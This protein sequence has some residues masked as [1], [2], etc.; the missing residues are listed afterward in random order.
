[1]RLSEDDALLAQQV[2]RQNQQ[3][4][5]LLERL[6]AAELELLAKASVENFSTLKGRVQMLTDILQQIKP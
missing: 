6:R 2:G 3:F 5:G 4:V 1:M